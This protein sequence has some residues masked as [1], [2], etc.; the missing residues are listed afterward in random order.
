MKNE[1]TAGGSGVY[2]FGQ[3]LEIYLPFAK[4][5]AAGLGR[6]EDRII[7][8]PSVLYRQVES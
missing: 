7:A 4:L 5:V 3:A 8:Y 6:G 2:V 1:A